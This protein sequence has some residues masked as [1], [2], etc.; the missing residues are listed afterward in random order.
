MPTWKKLLLRSAGFGA[1][2]ALM[3]VAVVVVWGWYS[4]RPKRTKPWNRTAIL[5]EYSRIN[6]AGEDKHFEFVYF[7]ENTTN[8]DF[9]VA[10]EN[11]LS[12]YLKVKPNALLACQECVKIRLPIF[13]PAKRKCE[14][15]VDLL[16]Y[17]LASNVP[18]GTAE[19][20]KQARE[21][22]V[23]YLKTEL[24]TLDGFTLFDGEHRYEIELRAGWN[25]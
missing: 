16:H 4:A 6:A 24:S 15:T 21:L 19:E 5:A 25:Q 2:F 12:V 8:E 9:N 1:G 13:I 11:Q 14:I 17:N 10:T 22:V 23:K 3:L 7:L 20:R 18:T